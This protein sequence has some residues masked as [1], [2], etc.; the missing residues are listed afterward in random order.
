MTIIAIAA[1]A[2]ANSSTARAVVAS[3]NSPTPAAFADNQALYAFNLFLMTAA[4]AI[5]LLMVGLQV[6]LIRRDH[7]FEHPLNPVTLWRIMQLLAGAA[8]ALRGGAEGFYLWAWSSADLQTIVVAVRAKRWIDPLSVA[9]VFAWFG[10]AILARPGIEGQL[11]KRPLPI[12]MW[13]RWP[14]LR[15]PATMIGLAF[16]MAV[17]AVAFR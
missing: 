14:A 10:M 4:A 15:K 9:C 11:K 2:V 17:A 5:G 1:E 8:L 3:I 16:G 6:N 13:S 7:S 12:D